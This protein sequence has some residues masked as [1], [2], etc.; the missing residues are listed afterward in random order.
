MMFV[1]VVETEAYDAEGNKL[2]GVYKKVEVKKPGFFNKK[3]KD[4][5]EDNNEKAEKSAKLKSVA[6]KVGIAAACVG[7]ALV[8]F[9][10]GSSSSEDGNTDPCLLTDSNNTV[11]PVIESE[12]VETINNDVTTVE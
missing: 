6:K 11:E 10:L 8:A 12:A 5:N 2:E 7:A 4:E 1:N 3:S 9:K